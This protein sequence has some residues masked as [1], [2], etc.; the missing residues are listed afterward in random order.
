MAV[1]VADVGMLV[2]DDELSEAPVWS[3]VPGSSA[4]APH[5]NVEAGV[6]DPKTD[7]EDWFVV[8]PPNLKG[9]DVEPKRDVV[10]EEVCSGE[11]KREDFWD[12]AP[13]KDCV[14]VSLEKLG[15]F[16]LDP[17]EEGNPKC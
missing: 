2:I 1:F 7:G 12:G 17:F 15:V 16:K 5:L 13:N 6:L 8:E 11:L 10:V 9:L 4:V 3:P 14:G